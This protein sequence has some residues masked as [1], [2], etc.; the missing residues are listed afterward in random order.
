MFL[1]KVFGLLEAYLE[2]EELTRV[3]TRQIHYASYA[4]LSYAQDAV[5]RQPPMTKESCLDRAVNH[6]SHRVSTPTS[7]S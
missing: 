6:V 5:R 7:T 3:V 4:A 2:R 1:I